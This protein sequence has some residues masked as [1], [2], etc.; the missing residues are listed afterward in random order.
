MDTYSYAKIVQEALESLNDQKKLIALLQFKMEEASMKLNFEEAA[1]L[2][3]IINAIKDALHI[4]HVELSKLED[5]D[6]F[7]IEIMEKTAV[8]MRLFIREGKIVSTSHT[9]MQM[10][11]N[12]L[13]FGKSQ[14]KKT[15][16][17]CKAKSNI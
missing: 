12:T 13:L 2:R 1:K 16:L 4:T 6:V 5:Y 8:V 17:N 15:K 7:A 11:I 14:P 9:L 3:D 10:P